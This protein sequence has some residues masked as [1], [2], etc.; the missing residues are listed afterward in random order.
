[1]SELNKLHYV[2]VG[3]LG[4]FKPSGKLH[5]T[6]GNVDSIFEH[7]RKSNV[8][9][10]ALHFHGGGVSEKHGIGRVEH[11]TSMYTEAGCH[12]VFFLWESGFKESVVSN[13][14]AIYSSEL[15][16]SIRKRVLRNVDNTF[17]V[18][19]GERGPGESISFDEIEG[20]LLVQFLFDFIK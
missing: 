17:A 2:N 12:P 1:M 8:K 3:S 9:K 20:H 18:S 4:T 6:P 16:Q 15:A 19:S 13:L 10:L 5:T 14:D 11:L 7:L